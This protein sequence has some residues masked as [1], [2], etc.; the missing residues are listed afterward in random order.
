MGSNEFSYKSIRDPLYGY[1]GLTRDET[2]IVDTYTFRRLHMIKQLSHAYLVYPSALHTRFEHSLGCLYMADRMC[3]ELGADQETRKS[4][5]LAAL[6]HDVGHGPFSHLF[7]NVLEHVNQGITTP[8]ELITSSII[9]KGEI[10]DVIEPRADVIKNLL[11]PQEKISENANTATVWSDIVTSNLDADK[12]DYLRRDSYHAG[13]SYG[14]FDLERVLYTLR[15]SPS[16][17]PRQSRLCIDSKGIDAL[18]SYRLARYL[19]HAQ[20]YEHHARLVADQMFLQALREAIDEDVI[21]KSD[22]TIRNGVVSDEFIDFYLG[23]DDNTVYDR[24]LNSADARISK[25]IL[26]NIKRRRLLKRACEF[27]PADFEKYTDIKKKLRRMKEEERRDMASEIATELAIPKHEVIF[28]KSHIT[29]KLYEEDSIF[30]LR[31]DEVIPLQTHSPIKAD[32]EKIKFYVYG[33]AD[34]NVRKRLRVK[35]YERLG[36]PDDAI[37]KMP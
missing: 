10:G 17:P 5:R 29:I 25:E 20:V 21:A 9:L 27:L 18:E 14:Q 34:S 8:H 37:A 7:E 15:K 33:P 32:N 23:I 36:I 12:L 4:V 26:D 24:I 16:K 19:M 2:R 6:V 35:V 31:G 3:Q 22:L 1:I 28:H 13:V 11:N 30:V